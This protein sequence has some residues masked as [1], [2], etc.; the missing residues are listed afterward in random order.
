MQATHDQKEVGVTEG[1]LHPC[2]DGEPSL[3]FGGSCF[4]IKHVGILFRKG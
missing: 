3:F 1:P 4:G 2:I